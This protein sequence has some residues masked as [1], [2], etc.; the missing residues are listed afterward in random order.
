MRVLNRLSGDERGQGLAEWAIAAA[1]VTLAVIAAIRLVGTNVVGIW[2]QDA[3]NLQN[4][5]G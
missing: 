5:A 4:A 1:I 3:A 2:N